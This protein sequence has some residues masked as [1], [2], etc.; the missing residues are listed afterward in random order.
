MQSINHAGFKAI[1]TGRLVPS[2][3][4]YEYKYIAV[5][6]KT[7]AARA[8]AAAMLDG[9]N[10]KSNSDIKM[11]KDSIH[12]IRHD[13]YR[14]FVVQSKKR[15]GH[16]VTMETF[17]VHTDFTTQG[18]G[19]DELL[20]LVDPESD[21]E[22][23]PPGF[24]QRFK[25]AVRVP[26]QPE[27]ETWLWQEGREKI[28]SGHTYDG[29]AYGRN[30]SINVTSG[31]MLPIREWKA[32]NA[33]V[34]ACSTNQAVWLDVI[35]NHFNAGIPIKKVASDLYEGDGWSLELDGRIWH[36]AKDG[37]QIVDDEGKAHYASELYDMLTI[38]N[39][40]EGER[41]MITEGE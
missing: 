30:S 8:V 3:Y 18:T 39:I 13:K 16:G 6:D 2:Q 41:L 27:W 9:A 40:A 26:T 24:Y 1:C 7:T 31:K 17:L 36:A 5:A 29:W 4:S 38:I 34:W 28:Q 21:K 12:L 32:E 14:V 37:I 35:R 23:P 15:A 11:G 25:L 20:F 10:R 22:M 33:V 19:E